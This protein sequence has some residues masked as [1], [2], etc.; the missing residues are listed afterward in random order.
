MQE[1]GP[2]QRAAVLQRL[3]PLGSVEQ[4]LNLAVADGVHDI[5]P[6]LGGLE[7]TV[8]GG[9]VLDQE[10]LRTG[11]ADD[12][13]TKLDQELDGAQNAPVLVRVAHRHEHRA[14]ARQPRAAAELAFGEGDLE[15]A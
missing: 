8:A 5:G 2:P 7:N 1:G 14:L 15:G 13:K 4:E 3:I 10:A 11:R 12:P 9:A 6:T